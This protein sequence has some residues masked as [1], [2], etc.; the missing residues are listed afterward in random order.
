MDPVPVLIGLGCVALVGL[1]IL[2]AVLEQRRQR[3]RWASL[4]AW[5]ARNEWAIVAK[6]DVDWGSR[7]PGRNKRGVAFALSGVV[8]GRSVSVAEYSYVERTSSRRA[9][10]S[11]DTTTTTHH[12]VVTVARLNRA[13]PSTSVGPRGTM[14]KWARSLF[15]PGE[16]A[17]GHQ[18]FD[19][20][21]RIATADPAAIRHWCTPAL[22]NEHLVNGAPAWSVHGSELMVIRPGQIKDPEQIKT[23]VQPAVRLAALLG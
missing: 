8:Q 11:S 20:A 23:S 1:V 21:Y 9:D 4:A 17:T 12:F 3:R 16:T 14:S 10:G 13:L 18:D 19:R 15:G 6:P 5:A 22:I 7:L 2:I